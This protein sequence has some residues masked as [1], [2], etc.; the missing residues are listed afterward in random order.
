MDGS[1][2]GGGG[3]RRR[4]ESGKYE[5]DHCE[6]SISVCLALVPSFKGVL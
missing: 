5:R 4:Q 1:G 2:G 6:R 3:R